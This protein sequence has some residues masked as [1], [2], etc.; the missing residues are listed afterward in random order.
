MILLS[1]G[2]PYG[3]NR[4]KISYFEIRDSK[5]IYDCFKMRHKKYKEGKKCQHTISDVFVASFQDSFL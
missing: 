1:T 2:G 4:N 3:K 5:I